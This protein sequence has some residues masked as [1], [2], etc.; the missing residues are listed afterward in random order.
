MRFQLEH[1]VFFEPVAPH[2]IVFDA[3]IAPLRQEF[4]RISLEKVDSGKGPGRSVVPFHQLGGFFF[5]PTFLPPRDEPFRV[6]KAEARLV[7]FQIRQQTPC[8]LELSQITAQQGIGEAGL[9]CEAEMLDQLDS[10]VHRG[11]VGDTLEPEDLVK[12]ETQQVLQARFGR[13]VLGFSVDQP[14]QRCLPANDAIDQLL[15]QAA[16]GRRE[17]GAAQSGVKEVFDKLSPARFN[18]AKAGRVCPRRAICRCQKAG[19][20]LGTE[21]PYLGPVQNLG[22]NFSWFLAAHDL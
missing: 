20:S 7:G 18:W 3:F 11:V 15:T 2:K 8:G 4:A 19:G 14:I 22:R 6:R 5:A 12:P 17:L 13:A 1:Q 10:L 21:A 16:V 9:C